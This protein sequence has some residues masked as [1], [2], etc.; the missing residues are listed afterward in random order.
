VND[1]EVWSEYVARNEKVRVEYV[2]VDPRRVD[3]ES[4]K[5]TDDELR[6]YF[7]MH[8]AEY[9]RP[10]TAVFDFLE[11][12]KTASEADEQDIVA[13]LDELVEAL[14]EGE[15]F[16]E[17]AKVYSE[18]PSAP[19]GGDLGYF[20]RGKMVPEFEEVAFA[21]EIGE[22]SAPVKT[23]FGYH[24][25]KVE[26]KRRTDGV[27]EIMARHILL[28]IT[29]SEETLRELEE[30]AAEVGDKAKSDGLAAAA[31]EAGLEIKTTPPFENDRYIPMVGNMRPPVR[32]A[33]ESDPGTVIGPYVGPN[34]Y[35]LFEVAQ[36]IPGSLPTYDELA[37]E[38]EATAAQ[39]PAERALVLE[40]QTDTAMATASG[41]VAAVRAGTSL[42][43][44]A[45]ENDLEVRKTELF[46]RRD[47][48]PG[49]G[50]GN[51][52]FGA[53]FGVRTGATSGVVKTEEP[54]RFYVLRVQ[55]KIAADQEAYTETEEQLR[56]ELMQ[57]EQLEL[58]SS[59]I[60]GLVQKAKIEDF[61]DLY[62]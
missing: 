34:A 28:Q 16:A 9:E 26:D 51:E 38:A 13:R 25:I 37:A 57:R 22:V 10:P 3:R 4:I 43:D 11:F 33:F 24:I 18:G 14:Q 21:L 47:Y 52:F 31:E 44:A 36:R 17:L 6:A 29:P 8:R 61:R 7:N 54:V 1:N 41:I 20:S 53:A 49:V 48:V 42:E 23:Q 62:F 58:L 27:D 60:E 35:Y 12:P 30:R 46:S 45:T 5:P 56:G 40:R 32:R 55:E 2:A 59:W 39:H 19:Q 50:R 15:D